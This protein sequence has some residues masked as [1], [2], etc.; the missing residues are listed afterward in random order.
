MYFYIHQAIR[1]L[2]L[3]SFAGFLFKLHYFE[4]IS[5]YINPKYIGFSQVASILFLFLFFIQVPRIWSS[6]RV[7]EHDENCGPWGCNHEDG[8]TNRMTFRNGIIYAIIGLPVIT[9]VLLPAKSLDASIALNRGALMQ[10]PSE[11]EIYPN[12]N[13]H[14]HFHSDHVP[15]AICLPLDTTE[16][17]LLQH[18]NDLI[19]MEKASF[20]QKFYAIT[21][22]PEVVSGRNI[23]V[24]GFVLKEEK[25]DQIFIGRFLITHCVADATVIGFLAEMEQE[26]HLFEGSWV[27][28]QGVLDVRSNGRE[29]A[30]IPIIQITR[31]EVIEKPKEP[32][33]YP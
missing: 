16:G 29:L 6:R 33:I 23:A 26:V 4:E 28:V 18:E 5:H 25:K 20:A 1:A 15:E 13:D 30:P 27:S 14:I 7:E 3:L 19:V 22:N 21:K 2:I 12:H 32:Y 9:G 10:Q 17:E 11:V 24:E 8:Y 31:I